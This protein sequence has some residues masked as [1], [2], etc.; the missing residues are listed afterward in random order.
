VGIRQTIS[1]VQ[2]DIINLDFA[3]AGERRTMKMCDKKKQNK[4]KIGKTR[5]TR[6]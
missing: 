4:Q 1:V 6:T 5:R 3:A 2:T